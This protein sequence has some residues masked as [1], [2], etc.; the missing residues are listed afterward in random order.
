LNSASIITA[1]H[2]ARLFQV[3]IAIEVLFVI[4]YATDVFLKER[5]WLLHALFD[6]DGEANIP[7]WFSSCQLFLIGVVLFP[8]GFARHKA[9]RPSRQFLLVLSVCFLLLSPDET[10]Q[11]HERITQRVGR[12]Y[13]DWLPEFIRQRALLAITLLAAAIFIF[14]LAFRDF[15]AIWRWSPRLS[16][17]A[18]AGVCR[19]IIGAVVLEAIGYKFLQYGGPLYKFE[20]ALEE[21]MEMSGASLVLYFAILLASSSVE[22]EA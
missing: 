2:A 8:L 13:I 16:L 1:R 14:W 20:V 7:T 15:S 11:L 5:F 10:A 3:L 19:S 6:L 9:K 18:M 22:S 4:V 17:L 21:F 12:R